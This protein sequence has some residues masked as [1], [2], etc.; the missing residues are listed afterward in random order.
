MIVVTSPDNRLPSTRAR[1]NRSISKRR[2]LGKPSAIFDRC[3]LTTDRAAGLRARM[4]KSI[5]QMREMIEYGD[6]GAERCIPCGLA[7][8]R[9]ARDERIIC[10]SR[11]DSYRRE[12][13]M[14]FLSAALSAPSRASRVTD[15]SATPPETLNFHF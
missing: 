7:E 4:T 8:I 12:V 2:E 11:G 3:L 1:D 5:S 6:E 15:E 14:S 13:H 10:K 9:N